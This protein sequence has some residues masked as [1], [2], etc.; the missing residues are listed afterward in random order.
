MATKLE[1][2]LRELGI[3]HGW[4]HPFFLAPLAHIKITEDPT[5]ST[6]RVNMDGKVSVNP[7]FCRKLTDSQKAGVLFHEVMHLMMQ[8]AM[9]SEGRTQLVQTGDGQIVS[10]FNV[11]ADMA[12]NNVLQQMR[13]ALPEGAL[14]P[15]PEHREMNAEQI[16]D[17]LAKTLK[18]D[19]QTATLTMPGKGKGKKGQPAPG[20]SNGEP[21]VGAGCGVDP[22]EGEG[23]KQEDGEGA[24]DTPSKMTA[25]EKWEQVAAQARAMAA[26]TEAGDLLAKLFTRREALRW[27]RLIRSCFSRAQAQ[28][29]R[30]EQTWTRRSRRMLPNDPDRRVSLPGWKATKAQGCVVFDIS[31]S[32]SDEQVSRSVDQA[33]RIAEIAE[34]KV[35][36]VVHDAGVQYSGWLNGRSRAE[37][38]R[39]FRG[40]GGT[41]FNPAY[42][43]VQDSGQRFDFMVHTTDGECWGEWP[44]KPS[45]VKRL[46]VA[47]VGE[48]HPSK[49]PECAQS[50]RVT[51][52]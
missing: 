36:V 30:D 19:G 35:W 41:D 22:G 3:G 24:G 43:A 16:Y 27:E 34:A 40:R 33:Q 50:V 23:E 44:E 49:M 18:N 47:L 25:G 9:R 10:L 46:I 48:C 8:H 2:E 17:E 45:N 7:D 15:L 6:M 11:A 29:G 5:V 14:Y 12:I 52:G 13:V 4:T 42:K 37:Y 21:A 28:H 1:E 20:E 51:M 39:V 31:G 26:G 38:Q 32:M